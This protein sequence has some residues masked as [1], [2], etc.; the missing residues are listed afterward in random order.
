M[1]SPEE[2]LVRQSGF[3]LNLIPYPNAAL[4]N[5][6]A[7]GWVRDIEVT[8]DKCSPLN[9][10]TYTARYKLSVSRV[11][12][13]LRSCSMATIRVYRKRPRGHFTTEAVIMESVVVEGY[14]KMRFAIYRDHSEPEGRQFR[15]VEYLTG[16]AV[17]GPNGPVFGAHLATCFEKLQKTLKGINPESFTKMIEGALMMFHDNGL[18]GNNGGV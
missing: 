13:V 6:A 2:V 7:W 17:K 9:K 10:P 8:R 12:Q 18:T 4:Q 16:I 3:D 11:A 5:A 1:F 14:E 15:A